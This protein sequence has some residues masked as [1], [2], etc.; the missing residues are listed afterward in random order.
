[1][2][3]DVRDIP[4]VD[5]YWHHLEHV[6]REC[7]YVGFTY[8]A[9]PLFFV[10]EIRQRAGLVVN[11]ACEHAALNA[12]ENQRWEEVAALKSCSI[13]SKVLGMSHDECLQTLTDLAPL[14]GRRF[15]SESAF[16]APMMIF[17]AWATREKL[18]NENNFK[19]ACKR[20]LSLGG[21]AKKN[22]S[23]R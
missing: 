9:P 18:A 8:M 7:T 10:E 23:I 17:Y 16:F 21:A 22:S 6:R 2:S 13:T 4:L 20:F 15:V 1:M 19:T 11:S 14:I 3:D 5:R 12:A